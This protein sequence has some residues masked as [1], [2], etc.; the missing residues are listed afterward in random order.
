VHRAI[1][2]VEHPCGNNRAQR[3]SCGHSEVT[4][5]AKKNALRNVSLVR[6]R[7]FWKCCLRKSRHK[8]QNHVNKRGEESVANILLATASRRTVQVR[9]TYLMRVARRNQRRMVTAKQDMPNP[10]MGGR[11]SRWNVGEKKDPESVPAWFERSQT[12]HY[13]KSP[14]MLGHRLRLSLPDC[15]GEL[16]IFA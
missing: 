16:T 5:I 2:T 13:R 10:V 11:V 12:S 4:D 14:V 9:V 8:E 6:R 15:L 1:Q 3:V 7:S